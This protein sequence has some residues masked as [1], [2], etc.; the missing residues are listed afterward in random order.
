L[1][2]VVTQVDEGPLHQVG[3]VN[4]TVTIVVNSVAGL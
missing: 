1:V 2:A 4:V 3:F